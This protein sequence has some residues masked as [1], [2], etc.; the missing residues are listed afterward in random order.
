VT[1]NRGNLHEFRLKVRQLLDVLQMSDDANHVRFVESL[2]KV[3]DAIG[4]WH[5]WEELIAIAARI[6]H[7]GPSCSLLHEFRVVSSRK[8]E[9][10]LLSRPKCD[11]TTLSRQIEAGGR[12]SDKY[13][14]GEPA[15]KAVSTMAA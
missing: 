6:L 10:A 3:K 15:L 11:R 4:E 2:G 13:K 5:D 8:Y 7:H 14:P 1:L 12:G 9:C